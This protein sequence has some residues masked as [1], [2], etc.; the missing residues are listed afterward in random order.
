MLRHSHRSYRAV[1][2]LLATVAVAAAAAPRPQQRE[3][4][5][6]ESSVALV[7]VPVFVTDKSGRAV[8]GLT[9]ADFEVEDAGKR[10]PIV[11]FQALDVD[12]PATAASLAELAAM[13]VAVQAA[14]PRQFL[15]LL[16]SRF[17]P[18]AGLFFGRKAAAA[19]V[20]DSLAPGD[21]VAVAT[22]G[23]AGLR[24]LTN[25][26]S[27][28]EYVSEVVAGTST[29]GMPSA[30]PL[31]F[32][33]GGIAGGA[34]SMV[35]DPL[36]ITGISASGGGGGG[37][38]ANADADAEFA[39]LDALL[40]ISNQYQYRAAALG[41]LDDLEKLVQSLSPLRGRKQ[42]VI[43]S[44]GFSEESWTSAEGSHLL[45][46]MR[47]IYRAAGRADVVIHSVDLVGIEQS[48]DLVS[49]TGPNGDLTSSGPRSAVSALRLGAGRG[50]LIAISENTGGRAIRPTGDFDK[51]FGEMDRISRHSY[52]IAFETSE[53]GSPNSR[54]RR[55]KVRVRRPGLSV[56]HRPEYTMS[57]LRS[58]AGASGVLQA[59]EAIGKG[60]TGGPLRLHLSTLPYRDEAGN[61]NVQAVLRIGGDAL[62]EAATGK[63][64]GLEVYGYALNEGRVLDGLAV[65]NKVDLSKIGPAVRTSGVNLLTSF[66][67]TAGVVDLRFFVRAGGADVIGS[68]QRN[69]AIPGF[70]PGQR[71]LSEPLFL[72]PP[73][74]Q[75]VVP[76]QPQHRPRIKIPF[77][78][79]D[80]RFV[81]DASPALKAGE[82]RVACV[83]A[84]RDGPGADPAFHV[85]GELVGA[86][87]D[88]HPV[89]IDGSPRVVPDPDGF[90]RYLLTVVPPVVPTGIY[91][92]RLSF[93][94]PGTGRTSRTET[95]VF[96]ER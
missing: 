80:D 39:A 76:I 47:D 17:S 96:V 43:F 68:I 87:G 72:L 74:G 64:L 12:A 40:Q 75:V 63:E 49:Q 67:V 26:T 35:S 30:D 3:V 11:A 32:S 90:D 8:S 36:G 70:T 5:V 84:W 51:A 95:A 33:T 27:D 4:P 65:Q 44:G 14:A 69:V 19:Y 54:A 13:P 85:T 73:S 42:V 60:L 58:E 77:Y 59:T 21:L 53:K 57:P 34:G 18:R 86:S 29:T 62:A 89:V 6:F 88:T 79:G 7:A 10:V 83:Y 15:L 46:K 50:T 81:P 52:V 41:F 38:N 22:T 28:H 66:P 20:R 25:F 93:Q 48:V 16:D 94:E 2:F 1:F 24:V 55:L 31:G 61:A 56:S 23:P 82:R 45:T 37:Q 78:V 92:L 71:V 9:A 91:R